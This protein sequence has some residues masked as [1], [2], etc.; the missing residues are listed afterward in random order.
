MK[1]TILKVLG[2]LVIVSVF[3]F[4][5]I[6]ALKK[7]DSGGEFQVVTDFQTEDEKI[8]LDREDVEEASASVGAVDDMHYI[9]DVRLTSSGN[10]QYQKLLTYM[11]ENNADMYVVLDDKVIEQIAY[12]S[13]MEDVAKQSGYSWMTI[14]AGSQEMLDKLSNVFDIQ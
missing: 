7:R 14:E 1:K 5:I 11:S 6:T 13:E 8:W 4:V 9:L 12:R 10:E 2:T 3:V